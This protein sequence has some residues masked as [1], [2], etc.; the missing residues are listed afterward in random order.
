MNFQP[1]LTSRSIHFLSIALR[2]SLVAKFE[3]H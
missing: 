1:P 2:Y 3:K